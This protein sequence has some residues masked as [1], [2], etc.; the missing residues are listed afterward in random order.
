[1]KRV[2]RRT[3]LRDTSLAAL[4][5]GGPSLVSHAAQLP[6]GLQFG[7]VT[8]QWGRDLA[9]PDLIATCA[10]AGLPGVELR[11]QHAHKVEPGLS[12]SARADV[13]RR[14]ADSSV[15]LIGYGS[16]AEFHSADPAEVKRNIELA[17]Q[18]VLLM[19]DCGGSGVKIKPNGFPP[20]V[21]RE[22][23][24]EQIGHSINE[25]AAFGADHGQEIRVE[26]HGSGTSE[27]PVMK[28]IFDVADHPNAKICWNS[29]ASDL[30]GR[31]LDYN[32]DLLKNRFGHTTHVRRLD[33][34]DYPFARLLKLFQGIHHP[35]W[36]LLEAGSNPPPDLVEEL[37]KQR[38]LFEQM[39]A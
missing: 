31:G 37:V 17:K 34:P 14:F 29:N 5:F 19:Q 27:I 24:I 26:V 10:Q 28:A 20:D 30:N 8:Y 1:M 13:R 18:Y 6:S 7:L 35:G 25:V 12:K 23:T 21:P 2:T 3:F 9:L 22:K 16:N 11:T 36:I 39:T 15:T 38:R 33:T 32:F 4:A